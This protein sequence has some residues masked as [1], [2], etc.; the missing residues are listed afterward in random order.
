MDAQTDSCLSGQCTCIDET[1]F[2][3]TGKDG[4]DG[5]VWDDKDIVSF[6]FAMEVIGICEKVL[7]YGTE[8]KSN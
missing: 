1:K 7:M 8:R 4:F 3:F 5:H 2:E 6:A